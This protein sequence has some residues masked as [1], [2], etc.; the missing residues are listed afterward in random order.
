MQKAMMKETH[1][2]MDY[3]KTV[4]KDSE[5]LEQ[6]NQKVCDEYWAKFDL[7]DRQKRREFSA[8]SKASL[9]VRSPYRTC[10]TI[11]H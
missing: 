11:L 8:K 9:K 3:L 1:L 2:Y 4:Q 5:L 6:E 7:N 10:L